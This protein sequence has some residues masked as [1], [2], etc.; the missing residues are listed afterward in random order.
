MIKNF[1]LIVTISVFFLACKKESTN[2]TSN[3]AAPIVKGSLSLDDLVPAENL[4]NNSENYLSIIYSDV[5]YS[6]SVD[7]LIDLP[8]TIF[9]QK[10]AVSLP[11]V[12]V[13]PDFV[14]GDAYNQAYEL[15][16]IELKRV[17]AKSGEVEMS[18][19]NTW[20]GRVH[21]TFD[22]PKILDQ[23]M[24]F[25]RYFELDAGSSSNPFIASNLIDMAGFDIDLKGVNGD[26]FNT[27][28]GDIIVGSNE[29][30][31]SY[32]ITNTDSITYQISFKNLVPDY[33]MGYFGSYQFADTL[34]IKLPFMDGLSGG[35]IQ[36]DSLNMTLSIKNG[37][38]L[39]AQSKITLVEGI[40][41]KTASSAALS[42]PQLNN[43]INLNPASGGIYGFTPSEYPLE[44]NNSN[45]NVLAFLE[46]LSDSIVLGY[47]LNINPDGNTTAGADEL[48]PG[49]TMDLYLDAEFPLSF[50]ANQLS[51]KDSFDLNYEPSNSITPENAS[52]TLN[53]SNDFPLEAIV[54]LELLDEFGNQLHTIPADNGVL[55]A[56]YDP[57]TYSSSSTAGAIVFSVNEAI[58]SD[59]ELSKK[60]ALNVTFSTENA[61]NI[62]IQSTANFDFN[63][64]SNLQIELKL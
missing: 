30:E 27:L 59:L 21:C 1:S 64:S 17:I 5:V 36:L 35:A 26:L 22:F 50:A 29:T 37:F 24:P 28:S 47:E 25:S 19:Y 18:I 9:T 63:L 46:N 54:Q 42:F 3:W 6:F 56:S 14:Y 62:K 40:N 61:S 33:A 39:I 57:I 32:D 49:S 52:F 12:T 55:A 4:T 15:D 45:S 31:N 34:G 20:P 11:S 51:L 10:T 38:N 16:Q 23:G 43:T 13:N 8:D 58:V 44:I 53:Y 41:S 48:F 60:I 7:T 2:W